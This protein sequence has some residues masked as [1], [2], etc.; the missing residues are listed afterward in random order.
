M[1]YVS[2]KGTSWQEGG[3][4]GGDGSSPVT[5]VVVDWLYELLNESDPASSGS[6]LSVI[7]WSENSSINVLDFSSEDGIEEGID[8]GSADGPSADTTM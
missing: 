2:V 1:E 8:E 4:K 3:A 7:F 6:G 5:G